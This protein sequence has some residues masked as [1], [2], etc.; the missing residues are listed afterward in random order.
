MV[1]LFPI[2]LQPCSHLHLDHNSF[3]GSIPKTFTQLGK[4]RLR[5]AKWRNG[6]ASTVCNCFPAMF[7]YIFLLFLSQLYLNDNKFGGAFPTNWMT[8]KLLSTSSKMPQN[9]LV[10][11]CF[12]DQTYACSSLFWCFF[13]IDRQHWSFEQQVSQQLERNVSDVSFWVRRARRVAC[14]L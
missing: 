9:L 12:P 10:G 1:L 11:C 2:Q 14:G 13:C 6:G 4:G 3:T 7:S 8:V 5:Y